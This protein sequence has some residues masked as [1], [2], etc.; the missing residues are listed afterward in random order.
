M[1]HFKSFVLPVAIVLGVFFNKYI[2]ILQPALPLLIFLMLYCSFNALDMKAMR[3]SKFDLWL[4][5]FQIVGSIAI[6]LLI[7]PFDAI[8]AQGAFV[9][10]LAPTASAAVSVA[11]LLGANISMVTTYLIICNVMVSIVAPLSFPLIGVNSDVPF[12]ESFFTIFYKVFPLLVAPFVL[13]L[14]TKRFLPK[15]NE[16]INKHKGISFYLWAIALTIVL[17]QSIGLLMVQFNEHRTMFL[18]MVIVSIFLCFIQFC[19]GQM[20]GKKYGDRIAG[21]QSLGQKNT[22]LAIW[23]AQS[24][25]NTLSS[26]VP[27][28]YI[29]WH[30]SYNSYQMMSKERRKKHDYDN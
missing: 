13:A 5:L 2:I 29:L 6:F 25:L 12:W 30:N 8:I 16:L 23:M 17:S 28:L 19:F 20:I 15:L 4:L 24:Y 1:Q 11:L 10:V 22:V 18:Y 14:L 26:I 9:T 7:R 27:T 3:F 21:G